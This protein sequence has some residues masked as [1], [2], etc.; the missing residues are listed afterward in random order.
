MTIP[1]QIMDKELQ[2]Q[3]FKEFPELY[4]ERHLDI[5]TSCMCRGFECGNGWYKIIHNLSNEIMEKSEDAG[6]PVPAVAQVKQK[7]GELRFS[8]TPSDCGY[9]QDLIRHAED[10]S[11]ITCEVC[12][13]HAATVNITKGWLMTLCRQHFSELKPD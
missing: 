8:I 3:I 13:N 1:H 2:E 10:T 7:F 11:R 4:R 6:V 5:Y 9:F 12:G